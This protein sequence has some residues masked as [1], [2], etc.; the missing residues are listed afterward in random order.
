M[1][2]YRK[3][4]NDNSCYS[5]SILPGKE[6]EGT[7]WGERRQSPGGSEAPGTGH[8]QV[9]GPRCLGERHDRQPAP[10]A[11]RRSRWGAPA[12]EG[13]RGRVRAK[14][15]EKERGGREVSVMEK[16]IE[17]LVHGA[18]VVVKVHIVRQE[19]L[20]VDAPAHSR[21]AEDQ[22]VARGP[23][24]GQRRVVHRVMVALLVVGRRVLLER[25]VAIETERGAERALVYRRIP[26]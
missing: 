17:L 26:L 15:K 25:E 5:L 24:A 11:P 18:P 16:R 13:P 22:P 7:P 12:F 23:R 1:G 3:Y 2:D 21:R 10:R 20:R 14:A 4:V 19:I 8:P 9:R 6:E